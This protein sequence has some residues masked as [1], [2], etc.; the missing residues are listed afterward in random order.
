MTRRAR[1]DEKHLKFLKQ[2]NDME[3]DKLTH[4]IDFFRNP[5]IGR[6]GSIACL[7]MTCQELKAKG[8]QLLTNIRDAIVLEND[9]P[10]LV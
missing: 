6:F 4:N 8:P 2:N 9:L 10:K 7:A 5:L 3:M 1:K